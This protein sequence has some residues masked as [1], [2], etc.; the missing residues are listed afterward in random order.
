MS[1]GASLRRKGSGSEGN[2]FERAGSKSFWLCTWFSQHF[3]E[4]VGKIRILY[5][6]KV[7][8]SEE[9]PGVSDH[10]LW[11]KS[12]MRG[13]CPWT[14]RS[15]GLRTGCMGLGGQAA[16]I[17][18]SELPAMLANVRGTSRSQCR[19]EHWLSN[20]GPWHV[21]YGSTSLVVDE[22]SLACTSPLGAARDQEGKQG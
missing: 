19:T 6:R 13:N 5:F 20:L 2:S 18:T 1:N 10:Q 9:I 15:K 3:P 12:T 11:S 7:K 14:P 17:S 22:N 21:N 8:T 4:A 16:G